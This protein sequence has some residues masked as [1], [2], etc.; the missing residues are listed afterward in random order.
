M[1]FCFFRSC[2][3]LNPTVLTVVLLVKFI[4]KNKYCKHKSEIHPFIWLVNFDLQIRVN[5][6]LVFGITILYHY[7][8]Q[9][10]K[11]KETHNH[12]SIL[13]LLSCNQYGIY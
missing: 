5:A 8:S 2:L 6:H 10:K 9:K 1:H 7:F 11:E 12:Q 4:F 13:T 3:F